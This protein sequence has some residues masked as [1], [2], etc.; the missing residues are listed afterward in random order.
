MILLLKKSNNMEFWHK[1][2]YH[3]HD[4]IC[5]DE[6]KRELYYTVHFC[7][8]KSSTITCWI[9]FWTHAINSDLDIEIF[10]PYNKAV[11]VIAPCTIT[12]SDWDWFRRVF[13]WSSSEYSQ[14]LARWGFSF[15]SL[16]DA[17]FVL[18]WNWT[19]ILVMTNIIV[20]TLGTWCL[21]NNTSVV[22]YSSFEQYI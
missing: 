9:G 6:H 1:P 21:Q 16:S 14:S 13:W 4:S 18:N 3:S 10:V 20:Y 7:Q 12:I 11:Q 15:D 22:L 8:L 17:V 19:Y 2:S 5:T